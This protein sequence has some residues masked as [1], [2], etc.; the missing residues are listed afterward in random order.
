VTGINGTKQLT[1]NG[2]PVYYYSGDSAS[3]DANGQGSGGVWF[4]VIPSTP[5]TAGVPAAAANNAATPTPA[6]ATAAAAPATSYSSGG[7][8]YYN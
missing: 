8:G 7:G 4:A 6:P 3:T 1:Y 2:W 5:T